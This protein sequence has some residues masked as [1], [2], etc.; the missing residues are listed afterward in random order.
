M[1]DSYR[2]PAFSKFLENNPEFAAH[3][4]GK[5]F[6]EAEELLDRWEVERPDDSTVVLARVY[7]LVEQEQLEEAWQLAQSLRDSAA[8]SGRA[9]E[10]QPLVFEAQKLQELVKRLEANRPAAETKP[11][12]TR[13]EG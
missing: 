12:P 13:S 3:L 9:E 10:L 11:G 6:E 2:G 1:E 4:R 5:H 7:L 8:E